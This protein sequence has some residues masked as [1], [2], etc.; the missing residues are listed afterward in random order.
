MTGP[1]LDHLL[2]Q[3]PGQ[4]QSFLVGILITD[5][6]RGR[7]IILFRTVGGTHQM[8]HRVIAFTQTVGVRPAH[9]RDL[10]PLLGL[11][12][13]RDIHR[14]SVTDHQHRFRTNLGQPL[15]RVFQRQLCLKDGPFSLVIEVTVRCQVV[16][17]ALAIQR[18]HLRHHEHLVS[19]SGEILINLHQCRRL[20]GT[21][22]SRQNNLLDFR[23]V[24]FLTPAYAL[25]T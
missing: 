10:L 19:H 25:N 7:R 9:R 2:V 22:S 15:E 16:P 21:W 23:H 20:T 1:G 5:G 8:E 3:F 4:T 14:P 17:A 12:I 24:V 11:H 13:G 18:R 6:V